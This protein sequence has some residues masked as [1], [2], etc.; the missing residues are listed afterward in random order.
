MNYSI[1]D[2]KAFCAVVRLGRFSEAADV[3]SITPSALSRRIANIEQRLGGELFTRTTRKITLT[4]TGAALYEK[5]LPLLS[6]LDASLEE[7]SRSVKGQSGT[8]TVAMVATLAASVLPAILETFTSAYPHVLVHVRDGTASGVAT[9]VE[10][11]RAD[12][13]ITTQL[14]F[15]PAIQAESMGHYD[16]RMIVSKEL[17]RSSGLKGQVTWKEL[18]S[19]AVVGLHPLSSTRQQIDGELAGKGLSVP[20]RIEVD[21][22][23]TIVSL[24]RSGRYVSVLPTSFNA[25]DNGVEAIAIVKPRIQRELFLIKRADASI[26]PHA[27]HF[28]DLARKLVPAAASKG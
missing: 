13:G 25:H 10:Q 1:E 14:T 16:F 15:G 4:P 6:Q 5:V 3:L 17:R 12:F 7:A 26:P 2:L 11:G 22:L 24:V 28:I 20:W 27:R 9:L 19:F 8:L 18:R 21:Q 23:S